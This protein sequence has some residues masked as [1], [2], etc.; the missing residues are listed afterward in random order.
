MNHQV[1]IRA[2][3]RSASNIKHRN[4]IQKANFAPNP[5]SQWDK[6]VLQKE[7]LS[8]RRPRSSSSLVISWKNSDHMGWESPHLFNNHTRLLPKEQRSSSLLF[9]HLQVCSRARPTQEPSSILP[10]PSAYTFIHALAKHYLITQLCCP[11]RY[12]MGWFLRAGTGS[13]SSSSS[14]YSKYSALVF[15]STQCIQQRFFYVSPLHMSEFHSESVFVS[16]ICS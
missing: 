14:F 11:P 13:L 8:Q 7:E 15:F 9:K 10:V 2:N 6:Q 1:F 5:S 4:S 3:E 12:T 16:P